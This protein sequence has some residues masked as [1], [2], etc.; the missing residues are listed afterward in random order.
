MVGVKDDGRPLFLQIAE[1]I[2]NSIVD[3]SLPADTQVP[4]TNELAAFHR[5]NPATAGKGVNQLVADGILYK[6]RGIGMFVAPDARAQLLERRRRDF[7]RQFLAPLMAEAG[8]LGMDAEEIK[9][10]IDVWEPQR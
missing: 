7:T 3:G 8:K 4:S 6:R 2:E 1:R 10:L 5:I 9:K